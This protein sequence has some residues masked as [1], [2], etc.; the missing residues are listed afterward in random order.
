MKTNNKLIAQFMGLVKEDDKYS[1]GKSI[2]FKRGAFVDY[3]AMKEGAWFKYHTSWDALL[4]VLK[5]IYKHEFSQPSTLVSTQLQKCFPT[6]KTL[7]FIVTGDIEEVYKRAV[8]YL[9]WY[10]M[11]I[12]N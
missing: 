1:S 11:N 10:Y 9:E 3:E 7:V 2:E 12:V 8:L 4:P 5:K 6:E